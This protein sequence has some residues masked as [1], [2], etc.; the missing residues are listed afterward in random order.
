MT[1]Q[2]GAIQSPARARKLQ[3]QD[4]YIAR[5]LYCILYISLQFIYFPQP[6]LLIT[7]LGCLFDSAFRYFPYNRHHA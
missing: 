3:S 7:Q 1:E 4:V 6:L 2:K 5:F